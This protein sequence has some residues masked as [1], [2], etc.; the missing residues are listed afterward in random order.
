MM[1]TLQVKLKNAEVINGPPLMQKSLRSSCLD[2]GCEALSPWRYGEGVMD[3][4]N[5]AIG[6][7][8]AVRREGGMLR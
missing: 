7:Q 1:H 5:Y 6:R 2:G 4:R 3:Q 8:Y